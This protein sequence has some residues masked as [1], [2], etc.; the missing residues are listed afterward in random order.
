MNAFL[1][2]AYGS[3]LDEAQMRRRCPGS[4]LV[5]AAVLNNHALCFA[6]Y[7][8]NWGGSVA[9]ITPRSGFYTPGALYTL[10]ARDLRALDTFE[11]HPVVYQRVRKRVTLPSGRFAY[12]VTYVHR[13]NGFAIEPGPKYLSVIKRAYKRHGFDKQ[14]LTI[15]AWG[16][17]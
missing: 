17:T 5:G 6:G 7:S 15:A 13:L 11:G 1:Y 4:R 8:P 16:L 12:A 2:F 3:N 14:P 10:T 9:S